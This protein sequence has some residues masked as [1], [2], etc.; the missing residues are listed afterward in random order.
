[1]NSIPWRAAILGAF[2][3]AGLGASAFAASRP[4][5]RAVV[6]SGGARVLW[7]Y[8][9]SRT[10]RDLHRSELD[11]A[12]IVESRDGDGD[13]YFFARTHLRGGPDVNLFESQNRTACE[14][15]CMNFNAALGVV[16]PHASR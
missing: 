15:V 6:N 10:R 11:I 13:P 1:G 7:I 4:C 12:Q 9:F 2:W 8:P 16:E 3:I 5:I 14:A